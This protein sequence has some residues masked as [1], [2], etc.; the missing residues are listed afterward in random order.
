MINELPKENYYL[1][2]NNTTM[3]GPVNRSVKALEV[4]LGTKP[5]CSAKKLQPHDNSEHLLH[6]DGSVCL[7]LTLQPMAQGFG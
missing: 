5:S 4:Q 2:A 3:V 1:G 6:V 7:M